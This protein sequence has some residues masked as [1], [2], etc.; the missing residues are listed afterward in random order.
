MTKACGDIIEDNMETLGL[1][2][3]DH[4]RKGL[5][6][7]FYDDVGNDRTASAFVRNALIAEVK[8][9]RDHTPLRFNSVSV[10]LTPAKT[11]KSN[12]ELPGGMLS[13]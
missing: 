9:R 1:V 4:T 7:E 11:K 10:D 5:K 8:R 3:N 12:K 6:L 2:D 13:L